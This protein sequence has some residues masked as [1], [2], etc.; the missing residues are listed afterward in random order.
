[1]QPLSVFLLFRFFAL[2]K[3]DSYEMGSAADLAIYCFRSKEAA[4]LPFDN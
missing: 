1:M 3:L 4:S 2:N